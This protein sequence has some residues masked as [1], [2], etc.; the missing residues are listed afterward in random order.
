[1]AERLSGEADLAG[2]V[3]L[4]GGVSDLRGGVLGPLGGGGARRSILGG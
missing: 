4:R 3:D 2:D 1:M